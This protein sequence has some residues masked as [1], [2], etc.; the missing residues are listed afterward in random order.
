MND[1]NN[2]AV[3]SSDFVARDA[4]ARHR[5]GCGC[6]AVLFFGLAVACVVY[7]FDWFLNPWPFG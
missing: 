1:Q 7:F 5:L 4:Q 2:D 3:G 6:A